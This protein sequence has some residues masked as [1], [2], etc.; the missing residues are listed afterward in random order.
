VGGALS[1][2]VAIAVNGGALE[3]GAADLLSD[4][5]TLKLNNTSTFNTGG[6]S[7]TLGSLTLAGD[8][9]LDLAS[10]ASILHFAS[11]SASVWSPGTLTITGW[12]GSSSGGGVDQILFG[13]DSTSLTQAQLSQIKFANPSGFDPGTYSAT[14][15]NNGELVAVPE[16]G[17]VALLLAGVGLLLRRRRRG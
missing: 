12:S 17:S 10:G 2:T 6:F 5:A 7:D 4:L 3:L 16:P 14:L 15:L 1:G 9:I 13:S 11:S 8:S